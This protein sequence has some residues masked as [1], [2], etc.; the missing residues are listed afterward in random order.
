[1]GY[2]PLFVILLDMRTH[3]YE[4]QPVRHTVF[5]DEK[6][7]DLIHVDGIAVRPFLEMEQLMALR[8]LF[9]QTHALSHGEG[10]MF[11]SVYSQDLAYREKVHEQIQSIL[12]PGLDKWFVG[13]KN[14]INSFVVKLPGP[15]SEFS[16]HQDTSAVNELK[17]SALSVWIPLWDVDE[18]NGAMCVAPG[19]HWFLS[20]YRGISFP[21]PF[22]KVM[23]EVRRFLEPAP[24]KAQ[25]AIIFDPRIVHN[26]LPNQSQ[27]P[28]VAIVCGI[29]P[30]A[31]QFEICYKESPEAE[32]EIWQQADDY[33]LKYP[34]FMHYCHSRPVSGEV[35][36]KVK[37]K[38]SMLKAGEFTEMAADLGL[39]PKD[40]LPPVSELNC[41]MIAEPA[42]KDLAPLAP[43]ETA[44]A[45]T[46]EVAK[47][48]GFFQRL[49][50]GGQ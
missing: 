3:P 4:W 38:F 33:L 19:T 35:I 2:G 20:P 50:G 21:F 32:I 46:N 12:Q 47:P 13:Y 36:R 30:E 28:R 5:R 43:V 44:P 49:F 17:F 25:E 42:G 29:F 9:Q 18:N 34:N 24:V 45:V 37:D 14:V 41:N 39:Q 6:M 48:R 22:A 27:K 11:Y 31:A 16:I 26:S 15:A 40:L 8:E 7:A 1:M 10:G 23:P